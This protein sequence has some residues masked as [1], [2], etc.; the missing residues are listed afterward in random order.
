MRRIPIS[1][2]YAVVVQRPGAAA[3]DQGRLAEVDATLGGEDADRLG[4]M[5]LVNP[6]HRR[7]RLFDP[8]PEGPCDTTLDR[9]PCE[10]DVDRHPPAEVVVGIEQAEDEMGVG[11]RR[12]ST[13]LPVT[14]GARIG[15]GTVRTDEQATVGCHAAKIVP[16][17][18]PMVV[19]SSIGT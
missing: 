6:Q 9:L 7:R 19:T 8:E 14:G 5:H 15:S 12:V 2:A 1:L 18:A 10:V 11:R 4:H 3:G 13:A 16:P 17:P